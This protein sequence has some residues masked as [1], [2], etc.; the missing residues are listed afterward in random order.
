MSVETDPTPRKRGRPTATERAQRLDDLL[1]TAIRLFAARGLAQVSVDEIAAEARVTKRT[2]YTHFGD[3]TNVF[4]ASI[5][6]LR[7]R[8]V[9]RPAISDTL[10]ELAIS[11][12]KTLHSD[13]AIGLHRIMIIEAT[14]FPEL[15]SRFY[16]E[17][18]HSYITALNARL[19]EP[20]LDRATALFSLLL[21]EPHRQRL[22]GLTRAPDHRAATEHAHLA[23]RQLGLPTTAAREE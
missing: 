22:L 13:E 9:Q 12:V 10:E 3:R 23:L 14:T 8:T 6:R 1:D 18:P 11:I 17:G 19:P 4:L 7:N 21:G 20:D 16:D 15:A 5:E 2:I